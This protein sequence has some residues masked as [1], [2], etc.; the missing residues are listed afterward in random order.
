MQERA[1]LADHGRYPLPAAPPREA[2]A[3]SLGQIRFGDLTRQ[4]TH[5][6]EEGCPLR[7]AHRTAG[8]KQIEG[9]RTA[10][11]VVKGRNS[12][13]M[14]QGEQGL[15]FEELIIRRRRSTSARSKL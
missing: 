9:V 5:A 13:P 10:Q 12:K 6:L 15:A 11:D 14:A 3:L 2:R 8:I 7:D 1:G 4:I